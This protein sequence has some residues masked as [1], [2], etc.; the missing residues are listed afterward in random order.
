MSK[1]DLAKTLDFGLGIHT[2]H[3]RVLDDAT[4]KARTVYNKVIHRYFNTKDSYKKI[5]KDLTNEIDLVQNSVQIIADKAHKAIKQYYKDD[6]YGRPEQKEDDEYP[7]R[8]NHGHEYEL[9]IG[10]DD[11][12]VNFRISAVPHGDKVRGVLEG[13]DED[14]S[15]VKHA[16]Q[17]ESEWRVGTSEVVNKNGE[18]RLHVNITHEEATVSDP[19][20]ARTLIGVD[21]N[22]DNVALVALK[23]DEGVVD[24]LVLEYPEIKN[25]RHAF[26]V[27]RKRARR[28][29]KP[30]VL[31]QLGNKEEQFVTD[32]IHKVSRRVV[33]WAQEFENPCMILEDLKD[34]RDSINYGARM[35]RRLHTLPFGKLQK[36]ITYK[37]GF[38][39]VPVVKADPAYTSQECLN[40][41]HTAKANRQGG[42]FQCI[43]CEWQDHSDR[44]AGV[45]IAE[46]GIAEIGSG[47]TVPPLNRLPVIRTKSCDG[48]AS[49]RLERPTTTQAF[50]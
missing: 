37:A 16:L 36:Y 5:Q 1:L 40:C 6:G 41:G 45:S 9:S 14:I 34:M 24:S 18:W 46:R 4:T 33:D 50:V 12:E 13:R 32:A 7:L 26:F 48:L 21:V 35:N 31:T 27:M 20:E 28:A 10:E 11:G 15:L 19:K 29:D 3:T 2:G 44:K 49:G 38:D 43:D 47:W 30:S 39:G 17:P 42:R 22:E 23:E 25:Y 8:S